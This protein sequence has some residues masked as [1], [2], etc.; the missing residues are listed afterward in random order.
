M[1]TLNYFCFDYTENDIILDMRR[2]GK[3]TILEKILDAKRM[4]GC[5]DFGVGVR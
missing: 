4:G 5:Q 2:N 3:S 1:E